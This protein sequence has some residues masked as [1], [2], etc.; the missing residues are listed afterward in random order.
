MD[1]NSLKNNYLTI[2]KEKYINF[3]GRARRVE[4]WQFMLANF[5]ISFVLGLIPIAGVALGGL[6]S[7]AIMLPSLGLIVRRLKD[8]DKPW[9]WIFLGCVPIANF[10]LIY[11]LAQ[12]GTKGDNQFGS[13]P[14]AV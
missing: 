3:D 13:D 4:F 10:Y 6:Y 11:L 9:P 7:L 14:K 12:E 8:I 1:F 2:I 5:V